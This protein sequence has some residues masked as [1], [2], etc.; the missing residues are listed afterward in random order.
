LAVQ[1]TPHD[2]VTELA[3]LS[4][5]DLGEWQDWVAHLVSLRER[6]AERR[7][8]HRRRVV[9][10]SLR[11]LLELLL[12]PQLRVLDRRA[13]IVRERMTCAEIDVIT[14]FAAPRP[15]PHAAVLARCERDS[16][17][18]LALTCPRK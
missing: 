8:R 6:M 7:F 10:V 5:R 13:R 17:E 3:W 12:G 1:R 14:A 9:W 15:G 11:S 2:W 18:P 4:Y 16:P